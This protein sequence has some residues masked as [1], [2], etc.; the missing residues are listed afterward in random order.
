ML[1]R[2]SLRSK[3]IVA[4]VVALLPLIAL[5]G[6]RSLAEQRRADQRQEAVLATAA[7]LAAARY[8]ELIE[9]S[10]RLLAAACQEEAVRQ[11]G[12]AEAP[13]GNVNRCEA[14]L[15]RVLGNFPK[16]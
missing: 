1:A 6:W 14:Y 4:L 3:L 7:E 2:R 12:N 15:A 16:E 10:H 11:S 8:D 5:S 9:G 13:S